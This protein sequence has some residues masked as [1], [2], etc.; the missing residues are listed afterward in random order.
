[1]PVSNFGGGKGGMVH[2]DRYV[3]GWLVEKLGRVGRVQGLLHSRPVRQSPMY[4]FSQVNRF[5]L[6]EPP[7]QPVS[8]VS[9]PVV[10]R[11]R[12]KD[13]CRIF[14]LETRC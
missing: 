8:P 7:W 3:G 1:M 12:T 13:N 4:V 14:T 2:I 10:G 6:R 11:W 5:E 9:K